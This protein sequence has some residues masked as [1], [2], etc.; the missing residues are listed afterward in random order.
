MVPALGAL[1]VMFLL[2]G[3]SVET[4]EEFYGGKAFDYDAWNEQSNSDLDS[5][6]DE[7]WKPDSSLLPS[8][9][10]DSFLM[11]ALRQA[12]VVFYRNLCEGIKDNTEISDAWRQIFVLSQSPASEGWEHLNCT[13]LTSQ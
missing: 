3:R 1:T 4:I 12:C 11:V 6:S 5:D 8:V 13:D 9:D 2:Q 7:E 10:P